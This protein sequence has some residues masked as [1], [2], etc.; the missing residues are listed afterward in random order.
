MLL[1]YAW[2]TMRSFEDGLGTREDGR[3]VRVRYLEDTVSGRNH[4]SDVKP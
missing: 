3:R 4:A 2:W 1:R